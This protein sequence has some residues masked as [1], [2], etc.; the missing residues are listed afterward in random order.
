MKDFETFA[1]QLEKVTE[2]YHRGKLTH[3]EV[4]GWFNEN[5]QDMFINDFLEKRPEK[6]AEL[7]NLFT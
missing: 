3:N 4:Q 2:L 7:N 1:K 6:Q 5:V